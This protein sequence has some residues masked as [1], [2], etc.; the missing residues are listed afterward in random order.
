MNIEMIHEFCRLLLGTVIYRPYVYGFFICFLFF[1]LR[2]LKLRGTAVFLIIAYLVAYVSEYSATRNG[3]PFG[4]YVYLDETRTREL[5]LSNIPFWDSLSFVFLSYFSWIM[6]SGVL[7]AKNPNKALLQVKTA[8]LGGFLM[9]LLDIIIDPLTLLGDRWFLGKIY[10]YPN[11]GTYFGVTLSNFAGWWFVGTTTLL[12]FQWICKKSR[13]LN[14]NPLS[15]FEVLGSSGVYAS[16]MLF[17]LLITAYVKEWRLFAASSVV[18]FFTL[19]PIA[20]SHLQQKEKTE[21]AFA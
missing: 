16:V 15:R 18:A 3:F 11:G 20:C 9:M 7:Q 4:M 14:L 1:S 2:H 13:A 8:I 5:W 12:L 6:A 17:N 19:A 21:E 10:Y